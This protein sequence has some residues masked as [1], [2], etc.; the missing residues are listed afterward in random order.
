[1]KK[2]LRASALGL[3]LALAHAAPAAA[4]IYIEPLSVTVTIGVPTVVVAPAVVVEKVPALPA[5]YVSPGGI[6]FYS[7]FYYYYYGDVWYFSEKQTGP[8][9]KLPPGHYPKAKKEWTPPGKAKGK[10]KD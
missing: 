3:L 1:M 2:L 4:D 9:H 6:Y 5:V 7:G 10:K 8:W